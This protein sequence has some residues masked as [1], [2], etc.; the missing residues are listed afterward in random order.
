MTADHFPCSDVC[1]C[2]MPMKAVQTDT[3]VSRSGQS[4]DGKFVSVIQDFMHPFF[5]CVALRLSEC[6]CGL[7]SATLLGTSKL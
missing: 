7:L 2:K 4:I 6:N 3:M 5:G 1:A